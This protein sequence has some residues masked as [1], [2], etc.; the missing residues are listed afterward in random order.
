MVFGTW[1]TACYLLLEGVELRDFYLI[2][3]INGDNGRKEE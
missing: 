1:E 3:K 2:N